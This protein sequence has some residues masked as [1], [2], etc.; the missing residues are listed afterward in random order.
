LVEKKVKEVP[1]RVSLL[2]WKNIEENCDE[3]FAASGLSF[4]PL[5]V[6]FLFT[7]EKSKQSNSSMRPYRLNNVSYALGDA[8]RGLHCFRFP[9]RR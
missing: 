4:T 3:P 9:L 7:F 5:P 2:D 8:W 1:R 6:K